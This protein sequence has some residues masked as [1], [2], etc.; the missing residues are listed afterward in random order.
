M[1]VLGRH[2]GDVNGG[3]ARVYWRE[4]AEPAG[5]R[6]LEHWEAQ[7]EA[8]EARVG[9]TN[10]AERLVDLSVSGSSPRRSPYRTVR[11]KL[12]LSFSHSAWTLTVRLTEKLGRYHLPRSFAHLSFLDELNVFGGRLTPYRTGLLNQSVYQLF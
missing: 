6:V 11:E 7:V 4:E 1:G 3:L 12:T 5:A 2:R 8:E 9:D 10:G